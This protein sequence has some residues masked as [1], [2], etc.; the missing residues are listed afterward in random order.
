M[1]LPEHKYYTLEQAA[2]RAGCGVADLVH[3]AAIGVLELCIKIPSVGFFSTTA[4]SEESSSPIGIES[5]SIINDPNVRPEDKSSYPDVVYDYEKFSDTYQEI[6]LQDGAQK[7]HRNRYT[8]RSE[9][10][11]VTEYYDVERRIKGIEKW[12]GLLAVPSIWINEDESMLI[13]D[14]VHAFNV[15]VLVPPRVPSFVACDDYTI[16]EFY[17]DDWYELYGY[18]LLITNYEMTLLLNGGKPVNDGRLAIDTLG[19]QKSD[20]SGVGAIPE[21]QAINK[22]SE[23]FAIYREGLLK[24]AIYLLSKYP[25]ECRGERKEISPEKWRDCIF[26]HLEEIPALSITN[27]DVM[28]KHLRNAVNGKG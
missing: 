23:R 17:L 18:D 14:L 11:S 25:N 15:D 7:I 21:V 6:V 2:K 10:L 8:Y 12:H 22:K 1:P 5:F 27:E 13:D 16:G 24:S 3:F 19:S 20:A 28:L 26:N 4:K 9:Y